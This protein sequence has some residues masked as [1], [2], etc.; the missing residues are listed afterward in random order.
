MTSFQRV[1]LLAC[2]IEML[3]CMLRCGHEVNYS[4]PCHPGCQD[5]CS[6]V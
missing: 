5:P 3:L 4:C 6:S 1:I 2:I